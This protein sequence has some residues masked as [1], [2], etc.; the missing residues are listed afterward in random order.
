MY[1]KIGIF[2][3][4]LSSALYAQ[5]SE[6]NNEIAVKLNESTITTERY[7]ETPVIETAKNVTIITS[8]EI[9]KRGYKT[10]D[11]ALNNVPGLSFAGGYLSM[12]GQVPSMG[13]KHL[14]VL[15]DGIPQNGMDNRSFD[16]DFIPVEQ[17]EKIEV[18]PAGGAIMYGGNATSGVINIITKDN[19]NKKYWGN[20]GLLIGSFNER[21]YKL[22]Y[23]TNINDKLSIDAKYINKDKDGYRD[24]TK[25]ESEFGEIGVK[26]KLNDGE[27]GV[28]YIRNER[29]SVGSGYLTKQQYDEDRK[30]NDPSYKE[31]I[32]HDTQDK[33]IL[34]FNKKLTDKLDFSAVAEYR[35][36]EY[37]YSQPKGAQYPSYKSR[38]KNTDSI[39]T[40]TQLKYKY[41]EKSNLIIGGDY[42]KA[43][44]KEDGNSVLKPSTIYRKTYTETDYEAFG[45]YI[46]NKYAYNNF[47][48]T[49]GIRVEKSEFDEDETTYN[50]N[51]TFKNKSNTNDSNTNTN[52]ELAVN[53]LFSEV[54]S[55]YLS[56]NKVYRA[57]NL[58]E[59]SSWKTIKD[60]G[61]TAPKDSQEV[62][63]IEIG[64]KSLIDNV[65]LSGALF[66]I[67][68]NKE[69]MYDYYRDEMIDKSESGSYYNLDGKTE[70]IGLE[71]ASEQYFDKITL[72]E[73]FTYLFKHELVDGPYKGNDIPGMSDTVIGLGAT[74][75]ATPNLT[76]N[77]ESNYH[78]KA[79]LI[80]DYYNR[81]SKAN[82]YM[83]TNI[84]AKYNFNNGVAVSAGIDNVFNEI[85]CDYITYAGKKINYSP[86]PERTYYVSAEYK[87]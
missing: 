41:G 63:T 32:A 37:T 80:N 75:E 24:Y 34:E 61:E 8:Q 3:L 31:K 55:G 46:L 2:A 54:T 35:E 43:T 73:S 86:S 14:V 57:P 51:G 26:Y 65:Y 67:K 17:I 72:R 33:Y 68:G 87:F 28:K 69:I 12:R 39:Y 82:S 60:T 44:V 13:N 76:F 10:V 50:S 59:Y 36:R 53:Y 48:F 1:K 40:N 47:I 78:S 62:D 45:G 6:K 11:E 5:E 79:Y 4:I 27:I 30:Q 20:A 85:Y 9:E 74:Y 25:R 52:Y 42:S 22:N 19:E 29:E 66:Y 83:V 77:I 38:I 58:T 84:S 23:G 70:R 81:V 16:L 21:K 18:V 64:V 15:L 56:Y 49:Q 7:E 71:L